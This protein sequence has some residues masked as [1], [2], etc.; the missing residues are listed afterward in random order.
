MLAVPPMATVVQPLLPVV[1]NTAFELVCQVTGI[2]A[3]DVI[4]WTFSDTNVVIYTGNATT[5]G[6]FTV[7]IADN[8][9]GTYIC[10]ASNEF[11][12]NEDSITIMRAGILDIINCCSML[13]R[14]SFFF[15][16]GPTLTPEALD[17]EVEVGMS[18]V[19]TVNITEF[20]LEITD[21]DIFWTR[22]GVVLVNQ[23]DGFTITSTSLDSPPGMSMLT[24]AQVGTPSMHSGE[25]IVNATNPA[26]SDS[27]TFNVTVTGKC[28]NCSCVL[29]RNILVVL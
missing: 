5:G 28:M 23:M 1:V 8:D 26:G 6:N 11:G 27:S 21:S 24:L 15:S 20:N 2:D 19:L 18:L 22:N 10:T 4:S 25:Y 17:I 3:P 16:V 12:S 13:L 7:T 14:V 9:F 29:I